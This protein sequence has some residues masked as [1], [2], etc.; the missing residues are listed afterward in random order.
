MGFDRTAA[1]RPVNMT[2]NEGL[3]RQ[4]R[5]LTGNLSETVETLLARFVD[6]AEARD[7]RRQREIDE[8]IAATHAF[9]AK[10]G[11]WGDA[12]GSL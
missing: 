8:P 5:G 10:H 3:V 4:A 7:S 6:A 2:L 9:L 11:G 12:F 1:K